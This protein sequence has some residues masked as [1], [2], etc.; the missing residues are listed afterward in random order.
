MIQS[1]ETYAWPATFISV[2]GFFHS[3]QLGV[4]F[5]SFCPSVSPF[6]GRSVSVWMADHK[7]GPGVTGTGVMGRGRFVWDH[8]TPLEN[9]TVTLTGEGGLFLLDRDNTSGHMEVEVLFSLLVS[10]TARVLNDDIFKDKARFFPTS[11]SSHE[12]YSQWCNY[13]GL[14]LA[15]AKPPSTVSTVKE[16]LKIRS[17]SFGRAV[18]AEDDVSPPLDLTLHLFSSPGP[19]SQHPGPWGSRQQASLPARAAGSLLEFSLDVGT[20]HP[21]AHKDKPGRKH[22]SCCYLY[23]SNLLKITDLFSWMCLLVG[24]FNLNSSRVGEKGEGYVS[25]PA[26]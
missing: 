4:F 22:I 21:V 8:G 19:S 14:L 7:G 24:K 26:K 10:R 2:I 16:G 25:N 9:P 23:S 12:V 15:T 17:V 13:G 1:W 11:T 6:A 3:F 20:I 18:S 5:S